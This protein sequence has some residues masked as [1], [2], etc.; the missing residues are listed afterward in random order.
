MALVLKYFDM[1]GPCNF[2]Q[3]STACLLQACWSKKGVL[4]WWQDVARGARWVDC[5][6]ELT[7]EVDGTMDGSLALQYE[8]H[9]KQ[10]VPACLRVL[11]TKHTVCLLHLVCSK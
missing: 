4:R 2:K 9:G 7:Q 1:I 11:F 10:K 8:L 5:T 3:D 6:V